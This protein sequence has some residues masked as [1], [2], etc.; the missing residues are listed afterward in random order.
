MATSRVLRPAGD[1]RTILHELHIY[2]NGEPVWEGPIT[3]L[4]YEFD[5]VRIF[6]EDVLWATN[7]SAI[8]KGY[9]HV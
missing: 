1:L 2:R 7:R 9:N 4:E 3:R 5:Q 8:E 6:A